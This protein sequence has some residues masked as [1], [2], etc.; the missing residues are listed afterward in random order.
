MEFER[1][2]TGKRESEVEIEEQ[3]NVKEI[4]G[5]DFSG[6]KASLAEIKP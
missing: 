5:H 4:E 2:L 6:R 1:E 3:S